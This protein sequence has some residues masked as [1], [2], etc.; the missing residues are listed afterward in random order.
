MTTARINSLNSLKLCWKTIDIDYPYAI[1]ILK[2][3][4]YY[5]NPD[6]VISPEYS[7]LWAIVNAGKLI[8][9]DVSQWEPKLE[10]EINRL[11]ECRKQS[12]RYRQQRQ[13]LIDD[14][15]NSTA[16]A[17]EAQRKLESLKAEYK[18]LT[19]KDWLE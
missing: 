9:K 11:I 2:A 17:A 8:G 13:W 14:V 4:G 12:E 18:Q 10:S 5:R 6:Y 16:K 1:S 15:E 19:G 3:E 7:R